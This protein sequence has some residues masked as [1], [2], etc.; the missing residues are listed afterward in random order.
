[1]EANG[2]HSV[3][4]SQSYMQLRTNLHHEYETA[5]FTDDEKEGEKCHYDNIEETNGKKTSQKS[6]ILSLLRRK[7]NDSEVE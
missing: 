1:M 7:A 4:A 5:S 3:E 2:P 6:S